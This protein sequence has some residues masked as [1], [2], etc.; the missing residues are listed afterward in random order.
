MREIFKKIQSIVLSF[1]GVSKSK[2][3]NQVAFKDDYSTVLMLREY[4]DR[5]CIILAKG[6]ALQKRYPFLKG[7][8]KVVR[9]IEIYEIGDLDEE[10]LREIIKESMILNLESYE[11]KKLKGKI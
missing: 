4:A 5:V 11:L 10:L 7:D 8:A 6:A 3:A 9:H 1:E 2:S